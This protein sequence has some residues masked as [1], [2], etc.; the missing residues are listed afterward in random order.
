[1]ATPISTK[2][3]AAALPSSRGFLCFCNTTDM[4]YPNV[5]MPPFEA[6]RNCQA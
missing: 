5:N 2:Q 6:R 4:E 3:E 1:M